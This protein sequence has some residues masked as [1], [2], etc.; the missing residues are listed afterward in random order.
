MASRDHGL[1]LVCETSWWG[2]VRDSSESQKHPGDMIDYQEKLHIT[3]R[4][5][6]CVQKKKKELQEASL[7]VR[8][9][10]NWTYDRMT[11]FLDDRNRFCLR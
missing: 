1:Q 11:T 10:F 5:H 4:V 7:A 3:K 9:A 8:G 6:S 2:T